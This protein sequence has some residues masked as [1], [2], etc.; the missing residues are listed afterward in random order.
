MIAEGN[1]EKVDV[2]PLVP[3][4]IFV[5]AGWLATC[6]L[7]SQIFSWIGTFYVASH[8]LP[9]DYG[10][11]NLSTAFTEFAV[12][13]TNLGIGTTLVQ[14]QEVDRDKADTLFTATIM[15]GLLLALSALGLSYFGSWYFRN[16]DLVALTQFTAVIYIL[17]SLTI[18]PY[19]FLN[20]DM[21][22]KERGLLDMYSVVASI[23]AQMLMAYLGMGVW[24]LLW[25]SAIRFLVRLGL[26]F[27]YSGYKPRIHFRYSLLKEDLGFSAQLTLNWFLFVLKE[28]SIP[29]IMG[30]AYSVSQLGLLGFAGSLSGIPNLKIVQLLREVLLPLLAK[31][32]HSPAAQLSGLGTA[33]KVM[34]LLVLPLYFCG[35]YYGQDT[36]ACILP[37]KWSPMFPLFEVLCLVQMW[38][39]LASIVSIYNTAQGKPSKSTWFELGM[40]IIV[41]GATFAFRYLD[42]FHLA[43][44]WSG[45]GAVVFIGW[46][47]WQ[48]RTEGAFVRRFLGQLLSVVVICAALFCVDNMIAPFSTVQMGRN[49]AAWA[50]LAAR[51]ALFLSGYGLYLKLAHW[52]FLIGLRKK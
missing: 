47:A 34:V 51:V 11:S 28:R 49:G 27:W 2:R 39:V 41:P 22:F 3:P 36:L 6:K 26:A 40:A 52:D 18:V 10:L 44:M 16:P 1:R 42:L 32:A 43:H 5:G 7:G 46:F 29:I 45:L 21:R 38:N 19:N 48:F 35:W 25:G 31:R 14:R 33:L 15:L 13:L 17:S 24:T 20:R 23:S 4:S 37:E 30:R 9:A 8:L 50:T 12:I